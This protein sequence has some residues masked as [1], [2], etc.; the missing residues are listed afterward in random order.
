LSSEVPTVTNVDTL[1]LTYNTGRTASEL[2]VKW[3]DCSRAFS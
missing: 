2:R 3:T 1:T